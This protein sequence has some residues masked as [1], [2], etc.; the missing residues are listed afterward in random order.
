MNKMLEYCKT[1]L[2]K[3]S[4]N[5]SL[6]M[7]EYRKSFRYLDKEHHHELKLWLRRNVVK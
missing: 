6:F 4:F 1:V 7:K 2:Q 5:R 3:I